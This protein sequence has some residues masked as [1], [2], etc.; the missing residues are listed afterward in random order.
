MQQASA[1]CRRHGVGMDAVRSIASQSRGRER[2]AVRLAS[3]RELVAHRLP[4]PWSPLSHNAGPVT[5]AKTGG[6][7]DA[8]LID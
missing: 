5:F 7:T 2:R 1:I 4:L 6:Y 8:G 3:L